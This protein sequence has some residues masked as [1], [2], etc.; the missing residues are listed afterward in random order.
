MCTFAN[1]SAVHVLRYNSGQPA[2]PYAVGN[3]GI[4]FSQ[5]AF[6]QFVDPAAYVANGGTSIGVRT[7]KRHHARVERRVRRTA[8]ELASMALVH[9]H[10]GR[11]SAPRDELPH[12]PGGGH[13]ARARLRRA[14]GLLNED[15]AQPWAV[16]PRDECR[17]LRLP[18]TSRRSSCWP[19][20]PRL[21]P[22]QSAPMTAE[23]QSR[24]PSAPLRGG[25]TQVWL[26]RG[27]V[28]LWSHVRPAA[29]GGDGPA[30]PGTADGDRN[31]RS[32]RAPRKQPAAARHRALLSSPPSS[33]TGA[34]AIPGGRYASA[35]AG[36]S[37]PA[38]GI[39][40]SSQHGR[41]KRSSTRP[42]L[43][44]DAPPASRS[45]STRRSGRGR[46]TALR[47][48]RGSRGGR[49]GACA[50]GGEGPRYGGPRPARGAPSS[51]GCDDGRRRGICRPGG[52][53][54]ARTG[55]PAVPRPQRLDVADARARRPRRGQAGRAVAGDSGL[56]SPGRY[57][58]V[59]VV[60]RGPAARRRRPRCARQ[61]R[62]RSAGR[63]R[64]HEGGPA[65]HQ[66]VAGPTLR[67]GRVRVS[68]AHESGRNRPRQAARRVSR[69]R[70]VPDGRRG[71]DALSRDVRMQV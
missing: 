12:L 28:L 31:S 52:G 5:L 68:P 49:R 26:Q 70:D 16:R 19:I 45:R 55:G 60:V 56:P 57:H 47:P 24:R 33:A 23:D 29:A 42:C 2:L 27:L 58:R 35:P 62:D 17:T 50:G 25:G 7:R 9:R 21:H 40:K 69:R 14:M 6:Q 4:D 10:D 15:A 36:S 20:L 54:P 18:S 65:D 61:A 1:P 51:R 30:L 37:R 53:L 46:G 39:P 22:V 34:S 67:R 64:Q 3:S 66:R 32:R 11:R 38:G 41:R 43:S 59:S 8:D 48:S 71:L 63:P 44:R 13:H